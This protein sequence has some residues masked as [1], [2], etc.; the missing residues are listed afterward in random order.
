MIRLIGSVFLYEDRAF[1][2][3][4]FFDYRPLGKISNIL[5]IY[6]QH[7]VDE[8]FISRRIDERIEFKNDN[9]LKKISEIGITTPLVY[10]GGIDNINDVKIC[11]NSGIERVAVNSILFNNKKL[12]KLIE[13]IGFQGVI[14]IVPFKKIRSEFLV[15]NCKSRSFPTKVAELIR[16][17]PDKVEIILIDMMEDGMLTNFNWSIFKTIPKRKYIIQGSA[18]IKKKSLNYYENNGISGISVENSLLWKENVTH[19]IRSE[20]KC[21]E[22]KI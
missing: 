16:S 13:Y 9:I 17:I 12:I 4:K 15:Y 5:K 8:I 19:K 1:Q 10:S 18:F 6:D 21:F 14:A 7:K 22:K 20:N 3:F 2:T 11:I